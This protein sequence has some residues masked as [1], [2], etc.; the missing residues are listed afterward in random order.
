[1]HLQFPTLNPKTAKE[2]KRIAK[3]VDDC[4]GLVAEES[5]K[6]PDVG[7]PKSYL[8]DEMAFEIS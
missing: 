1:V 3:I 7:R 4:Y 6:S 8:Q 2:N 5:R